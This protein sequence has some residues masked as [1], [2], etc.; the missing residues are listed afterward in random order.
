M[1]GCV[2]FDASAWNA[3]AREVVLLSLNEDDFTI[4]GCM[5]GEVAAHERAWA[6]DLRSA[7]LANEYFASANRLTTKTLDAEAL[8]SVVV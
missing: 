8:T 5:D 1:L 7:G 4:D 3:F 2:N 6:S